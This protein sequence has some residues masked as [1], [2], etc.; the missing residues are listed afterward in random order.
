MVPRAVAVSAISILIRAEQVRIVL[1]LPGLDII[2]ATKK[3]LTVRT[4]GLQVNLLLRDDFDKW[5]SQKIN[6]LDLI[7]Q[8]QLRLDRLGLL[9]NEDSQ[10]QQD[11]E[12]ERRRSRDSAE[13]ERMRETLKNILA[14]S[15]VEAETTKVSFFVYK[16]DGLEEFYRNI[17]EVNIPLFYQRCLQDK[18]FQRKYNCMRLYLTT[19]EA[20]FVRMDEDSFDVR[21]KS[22]E[23]L[24]LN[25]RF[26]NQYGQLADVEV[27]L[28][29]PRSVQLLKDFCNWELTIK[30]QRGK[31]D[32]S[33]GFVKRALTFFIMMDTLASVFKEI[34]TLVQ[35]QQFQDVLFFKIGSQS[36]RGNERRYENYR[37]VDIP[38]KL[39]LQIVESLVVDI[40][41]P[42][43]RLESFL[44]KPASRRQSLAG[45]SSCETLRISL[46]P[47]TS[48]EMT[49]RINK[50][51][52]LEFT[53]ARIELE[54]NGEPCASLVNLRDYIDFML[55]REL[56]AFKIKQSPLELAH[57]LQAD[58]LCVSQSPAFMKHVLEL[59]NYYKFGVALASIKHR[60]FTQI[61]D[62][63]FLIENIIERKNHKDNSRPK[64]TREQFL[65]L[66]EVL[67]IYEFET[68]LDKI[69]TQINIQSV[70]VG[71]SSYGVYGETTHYP[72]SY[73]ADLIANIEGF[74]YSISKIGPTEEVVLKCATLFL[75]QEARLSRSQRQQH[76]LPKT[77]PKDARPLLKA[78][79]LSWQKFLRL[80]FAGQL[81]PHLPMSDY[82]N[83]KI[84]N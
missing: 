61:Q 54:Q 18:E 77:M 27:M 37:D 52:Y 31:F 1:G 57:S 25:S 42:S 78:S 13:D 38:K 68:H 45:E 56:T 3:L 41:Y 46:A 6:L 66:Y 10:K 83:Y 32:I 72:N 28:T 73:G 36:R 75:G 69:T 49:F 48:F 26:A 24:V 9:N 14:N 47:K 64:Y 35:K 43:K 80:R 59:I 12:E 71:H 81:D 20:T 51:Y 15:L 74:Q 23:L 2:N 8:F 44:P 19:A 65:E 4:T 58:E 67:E 21:V 79:D 82:E 34:I 16:M 63:K 60:I 17:D 70:S 22:P 76:L 5:N 29:V 62:P 7:K 30:I 40:A 33:K 50:T 55:K 84:Y 53:S 39:K 11:G